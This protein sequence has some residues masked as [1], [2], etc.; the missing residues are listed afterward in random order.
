MRFFRNTNLA[1]KISEALSSVLPVTGVVLLMLITLV[2]VGAEMLVAFLVGAV[3]LVVGMGLF[4]LGA[5][6]AMTPMGEYVGSRMAASRKVWVVIL[7][8][9]FVGLMITISEPDLQVLANQITSIQPNL[10]LTIAVGVGVGLFLVVAMLR[11]L[12]RIKLKYILLLCYAAVFV[13]AIFFIPEN[14]LA[15]SFDSGGVTTGP[16]TVP[17]IMALGLGVASISA[18]EEMTIASV[19]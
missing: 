12:F 2:P 5:E 18:N 6:T 14:F 13:M 11:I 8:S 15:V 1:E 4:N 19:W 10:V 7:V 9:F 3:M 16:M 17:F